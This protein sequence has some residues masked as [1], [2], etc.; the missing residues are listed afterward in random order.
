MRISGNDWH[1]RV[2]GAID[3]IVDG[4]KEEFEANAQ[5][6]VDLMKDIIGNAST[7]T[8]LARGQTGRID[9]GKMQDMAKYWIPDNRKY[10]MD[11]ALG[12]KIADFVGERTLNYVIIQDQGFTHVP[13]G[14]WI[15]GVHALQDA[16]EEFIRK[17]TESLNKF[18]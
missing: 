16:R 4:A 11:I 13:D 17:T 8:G 7:P 14:N 18:F 1:V 5:D 15:P 3:R 6:A 9:S 10:I 12:W 2:T